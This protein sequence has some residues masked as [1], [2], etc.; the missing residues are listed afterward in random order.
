MFQKVFQKVFEKFLFSFLA[1]ALPAMLV[2]LTAQASDAPVSL[3]LLHTNDLHSHLRP[4]KNE[5][6]LGGLARL[7]TLTDRLRARAT[8]RGDVTHLVDGGD[9]SEGHIYYNYQAGSEVIRLME[10][11]GYNV[12]VPGNHDWINGPDVLIDSVKRAQGKMK[13]VAANYSAEKY[14]RAGELQALV[15]PYTIEQ[16][17]PYR[18]A[19]I[20]LLTYEYIYDSYFAPVKLAAPEAVLKDL[21]ERL[22]PHV[23]AIIAI[24]HNSIATNKKCLKAAPLVNLIIGAH[25]HVKLTKPV[26]VSTAR[27]ESWIVETGSW[28]RYLGEVTL[29]ISKEGVTLQDYKLHAVDAS[30]PEDK[31]IA[32]RIVE[33]EKEL[34]KILARQYGLDLFHDHVAEAEVEADREGVENRMGNLATD[35]YVAASGADLAIDQVKMI[36][37]ALYR[38]EIHTSDVFNANPGVF[39]PATG[40]AWSLH[41]F[42]LTGKSLRWI[43]NLFYGNQSITELAGLSHSGL[44]FAYNPITKTRPDRQ[45]DGQM[46]GMIEQILKLAGFSWLRPNVIVQDL[47][48]Q[49]VPL[50]VNRTYTVAASGGVL[51]GIRFMNSK[52]PG[53]IDIKNLKDTGIESWTTLKKYLG[54][55]RVLKKDDLQLGHRARALS[56]DLALTSDD[57]ELEFLERHENGILARV[58]AT[59]TNVGALPV[60]VGQFNVLL[61]NNLKGSDLT[62]DLEW[63]LLG[64]AQ[65]V[66]KNLNPLETESYT[67]IVEIPYAS[68]AKDLVGVSVLLQDLSDGLEWNAMNNRATR[69]WK[70]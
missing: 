56:P 68:A 40:K 18:V 25:D 46:D 28:G 24:S 48:I 58:H 27:G 47:R 62:Q 15:P 20:G 67:W 5:L 36:Y 53:A 45:M 50:D 23:D 30:I 17:G 4:E 14:A 49:G 19:Y 7:K 38:G 11:L 9:F 22:S 6:G 42:Q 59:V 69:W 31:E 1:L 10:K 39:N 21:S 35:A 33:L 16:V 54:D 61:Q 43:L 41:T 70:L 32:N 29:Q 8:L 65:I 44:S 13:L 12:A 34:E 57:I 55:K 51:E 52:L 63:S 37:G 60:S 3:Q 64:D 26:R 2:T 66:T